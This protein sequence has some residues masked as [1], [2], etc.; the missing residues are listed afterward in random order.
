MSGPEASREQS[1]RRW[2]KKV[3]ID[4]VKFG[5][6]VDRGWPDRIYLFPD[7]TVAFIEWKAPGKKPTQQQLRKIGR[8]AIR[9]F[10]VAVFDNV[11]EAKEWLSG[12]L[13]STN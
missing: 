12:F 10:R 4:C 1:V 5:S 2:C 11:K 7:G 13:M 6:S 9:R 3:G 8:L